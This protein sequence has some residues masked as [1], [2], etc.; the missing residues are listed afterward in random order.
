[1]RKYQ[2]R[3]HRR[4]LL[5]LL[6]IFN[7]R[8]IAFSPQEFA[9][10]KDLRHKGCHGYVHPLFCD[11]GQRRKEDKAK[12][13]WG[14]RSLVR[15]AFERKDSDRETSGIQ[16]QPPIR[17]SEHDGHGIE[18]VPQ[19]P[20][21]PKHIAFICDGNSRWAKKRFLPT[22][23]G[24][25]SGANA[26]ISSLKHLISRG[27]QFATFYAFSTENWSRPAEEIDE[28]WD[29]VEKTATSFRYTAMKEKVSIK[30]LG[31][32]NDSRIPSSLRD[33]LRK[34]E[35]DTAKFGAGGEIHDERA[36]NSSLK[37]PNYAN[38][39]RID[40][41][42]TVCIAVN[43]GGRKDIMN[44]G[45]KLAE[46]LADGDISREDIDES[47]FGTYLCT[48]DVPDPDMII[49]TGGE[50]RLSNFLLWNL[51]YSELFFTDTLWPD[52]DGRSIDDAL[53]WYAER[54]RRFGGRTTSGV[55][56]EHKYN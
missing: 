46:A 30:I 9:T 37:G 7:N 33:C 1:M 13:I 22:A 54:R 27:V 21:L 29:V 25:I 26:L 56:I 52:F 48:C 24:H 16:T 44:A 32:I 18:E 42:L 23:A 10:A 20:Q 50:K 28:I 11:V 8:T 17:G 19:V 36:D 53:D 5:F 45:L 51:A 47:T 39:G 34:L 38:G 6:L 43:Y 15:C 49:R 41:G 3:P 2:A 4:F 40:C 12:L 14:C 55:L 31:D 35:R